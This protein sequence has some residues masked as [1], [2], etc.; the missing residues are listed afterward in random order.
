MLSLFK[1]ARC[2]LVLLFIS[3]LSVS[4]MSLHYAEA[5]EN[6]G[7]MLC[8]VSETES[9]QCEKSHKEDND[10][11]HETVQAYLDVDLQ[12]TLQ[13]FAPLFDRH[14]IPLPEYRNTY[15]FA[16]INQLIKPP[17]HTS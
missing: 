15:L 3:S 8:E 7:L 13:L 16:F 6:D 4:M 12:K 10:N 11:D 14:S 1:N 5:I 9:S 2:L 17:I